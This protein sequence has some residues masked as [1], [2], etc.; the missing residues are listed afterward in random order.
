MSKH[1]VPSQ[2]ARVSSGYVASSRQ[3]MF[4]DL[5]RLSVVEPVKA[6]KVSTARA[7]HNVTQGVQGAT[8]NLVIDLAHASIPSSSGNSQLL[9][10]THGY[11]SVQG[12]E[13]MS[14]SLNV[15]FKEG[16]KAPKTLAPTRIGDNVVATVQAGKLYLMIDTRKRLRASST[17]KS[18]IVSTCNYLIPDTTLRVNVT[19]ITKL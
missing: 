12:I 8:L 7:S 6:P 17:G 14:V 13:G 11:S 19:A 5:D 2:N 16:L 1:Q 10:T 9:A 3:A 4:L 18:T 15:M